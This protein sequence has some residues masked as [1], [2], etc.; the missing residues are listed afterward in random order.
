MPEE[1]HAQFFIQPPLGYK[2]GAVCTSGHPVVFEHET[3]KAHYIPFTLQNKVTCAVCLA[4]MVGVVCARP[5][6]GF[7]IE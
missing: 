5:H 6:L 1:A 4:Q 7:D 3:T 2:A